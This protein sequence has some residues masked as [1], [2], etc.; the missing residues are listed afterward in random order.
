ME[1][2]TIKEIRA[3]E[4]LYYVLF[5]LMLGIAFDRLFFDKAFGISFFIFISLC[6]GFFFWSVRSR[7][8]FKKGFGWFLLMPIG[9]LSFSFAVHTNEMLSALNVLVILMLMVASSILIEKPDL[10]WDKASFIFEM[11]RR[12]VGN[13]I[14]N[15]PM[16]FR[17]I[18]KVIG[19]RSKLELKDGKKQIVLGLLISL[20]LLFVIVLLLSSADMVFNYYL[21]NITDIFANI[22]LGNFPAHAVL[23][24]FVAFY[25]FG[26]VFG[27]ENKASAQN[28]AAGA[29]SL[30][31]VTVITVL[32]VLNILYLIFSIIQFSYLYGGGTM[33]LPSGFTYAEYARRGFFE[34][35]AVTFINFIIVLSCIKFVKKDSKRLL[36][37]VN[38]LLT[39][40]VVFTLN[41]L[42]SAN[43]KM[44]MYESTFGYTYLRVM[45]QLFMLL[46]FILCI[47]VAAGIWHRKIPVM[48]S[49]IAVS[50]VMWTV[51]NYVNIDGFIARKNIELYKETGK[52]DVNYLTSLSYEAVPYMLE[53]RN[54][55]NND[56]R[57]IIEKNLERKKEV[58]ERHN[59]WTEFNFSKSKVRGLLNVEEA[60]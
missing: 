47:I 30:E 17:I 39:V 25:L 44:N 11:L 32:V 52:L 22:D 38:I 3:K 7:V 43:F 9:L 8:K 15:I 6:I 37:T 31:A 36:T 18:R 27:G 49:I 4:G 28:P 54:S 53:I 35:A 51:I 21:G 20:P 45:V 56:I 1:N 59:S 13:V 42:F 19:E 48:K 41:M 10:E 16:P 23:V 33:T 12:G 46:L 40:L 14:E 2:N 60:K 26:Y 50:I 5:S 29:L 57:T 58:L 55:D 34:L 24:L